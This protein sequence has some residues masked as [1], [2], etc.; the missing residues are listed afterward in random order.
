MCQVLGRALHA[1]SSSSSSLILGSSIDLTMDEWGWSQTWMNVEWCEYSHRGIEMSVIAAQYQ[2]FHFKYLYLGSFYF[3][4]RVNHSYNRYL[5]KYLRCT[6]CL[7]GVSCILFL[8]LLNYWALYLQS[9]F[10]QKQYLE[11]HMLKKSL[12]VESGPI[13]IPEWALLWLGHKRICR[14]LTPYLFYDEGRSLNSMSLQVLK[15]ELGDLPG[16]LGWS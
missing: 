3:T 12:E 15:Q 13:I 1:S 6:V 2:F 8:P 11:V 4:I 16:C 14:F 5:R 10:S 9:G 7:L